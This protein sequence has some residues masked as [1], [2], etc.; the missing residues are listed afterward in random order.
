MYTFQQK[1]VISRRIADISYIKRYRQLLKSV[2]SPA[3]GRKMLDRQQLSVSLVYELLA[4]YT[5]EEI[6]RVVAGAP[7]SSAEGPAPDN[8]V[9]EVKKKVSKFEQYPHIRW[10]EMDN[11]L[12]RTADS[13]F[14]DRI[15]L[16]S[17]LRNIEK[18]TEGAE[19]MDASLLEE[20]VLKSVRM[21]LCFSELKSF[22]DTGQFMGRHPFIKE[23][24]ERAR[25]L[26]VLRTDPDRYFEERKNI[27]LNITRYSSQINSKKVPPA[28]KKRAAENLDKF[29]ALL[30]M[31]RE[32]FDGFIKGRQ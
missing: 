32:I 4:Y 23:K 8:A 27:E 20:I 25:V 9:K 7:V 21:E 14:S 17:R 26:E 3:A 22:N 18:D 12:V 2:K 28:R 5:E 30:Q 19:E 24:D 31:Y 29:K 1:K 15:N 10:R 13:I 11:P 6:L 16:W